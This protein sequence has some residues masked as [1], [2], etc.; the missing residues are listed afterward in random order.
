[1]NLDDI[2]ITPLARISTGSGDVLHV[3][4]RSD[5]GYADFGEAYFSWIAPRAVK[6]WKRHTQMTMNIV[7]PVGQVR[8]VFHLDHEDAFRVEEIGVDRYVRLSVPPGIW[9]GFQGLAAPQSM[10]MNIASIPH[11]SHEVE[12]RALS[13]IS[14]VWS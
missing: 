3:M 4:K 11:D 6:A 7:V 14:Y 9:F 13:E 5:V 8:F 1:M 12:R 10:L 2:V